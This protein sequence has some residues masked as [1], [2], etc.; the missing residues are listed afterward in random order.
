MGGNS[1][2]PDQLLLFSL[3][4]HPLSEPIGIPEGPNTKLVQNSNLEED[5]E[6]AELLGLFIVAVG[7]QIGRFGLVLPPRIFIPNIVANDTSDT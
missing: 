3:L 4:F 1:T 6:V 2:Y 7:V 5:V